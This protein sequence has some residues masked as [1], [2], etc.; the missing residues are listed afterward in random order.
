MTH[1][2]KPIGIAIIVCERVITEAKTNN[3]TI[4]STFNQIIAAKF[5]CVHGMVC[6]FVSLTNGSGQKQVEL[7]LRRQ[8]DSAEML[9][10]GG[11]VVFENP[12]HVIEMIFNLKNCPFT[13]PGL[14]AFEVQV[15]GEFIFDRRFNVIDSSAKK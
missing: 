14:Y 9:K 15:D 11:P 8:S 12:N 10:A 7:I 6:A 3:K 4:V 1:Q 5:P 2:E 13:E